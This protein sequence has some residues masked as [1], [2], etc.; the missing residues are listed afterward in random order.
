MN[1]NTYI[2]PVTHRIAQLVNSTPGN[3][4]LN[5]NIEGDVI[6][7]EDTTAGFVPPRP[8]GTFLHIQ[9]RRNTIWGPASLR[10]VQDWIDAE[11]HALDLEQDGEDRALA[12]VSFLEILDLERRKA[13]A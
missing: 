10:L 3:L 4:A 12:R 9:G 1:L 6:S 5:L 2:A 13:A 11:H 7:V 8:A